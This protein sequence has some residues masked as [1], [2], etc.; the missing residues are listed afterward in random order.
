MIPRRK[1]LSSLLF[2]SVFVSLVPCSSAGEC[3]YGSVHAEVRTHG[4]PW[5]NATAHLQLKRGEEFILKIIVK[6]TTKLHV[7]YLKL[8]EF[9]T[10]VYEVL[11][12]PS[13]IDTLL[14]YRHPITENTTVTY[15]WMLRVKS[16]T[17]WVHGY[18]PLEVFVQFNKN[19]KET[20]HISFDVIVAYISNETW[21][22]PHD[23][24]LNDAKATST[25]KIVTNRDVYLCI[26][27]CLTVIN[28]DWEY[29]VV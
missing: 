11:R 7:L 19:D 29:C 25:L 9:G 13:A 2:L 18:G 8:H 21:S 22:A 28:C 4:S 6:A 26:L 23:G 20:C 5:E 14:E 16:N 10:P 12:G 1:I 3:A 17:T 24:L 15:E 27:M